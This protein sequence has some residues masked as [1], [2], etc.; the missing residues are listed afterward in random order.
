MAHPTI[1]KHVL[2][3]L[4]VAMILAYAPSC[5]RTMPERLEPAGPNPP[6]IWA[7]AVTNIRPNAV[8]VSWTTD[9]PATSEVLCRAVD[10]GRFRRAADDRLTKIHIVEQDG[11]K[12]GKTY[13]LQVSSTAADGSRGVA[14]GSTFTP[15]KMP[16]RGRVKFEGRTLLGAVSGMPEI[17]QAA[18]MHVD[19][20]DSAWDSLMPRPHKWDRKRLDAYI[21]KVKA[22]RA[23]GIETVVTLDYCVKW[24]LELTGTQATWRHPAFGPPDHLS[25]WKEFC[26][27][28]MEGLKDAPQWYE[29]WNEPDAGFFARPLG[30]EG[31]VGAGRKLVID[32]VFQKNARYWLQDR[33]APLVFAAR[34]AA[35]EVGVDA[36]LMAAGWNHDYHGTRGDMLLK[37]GVHNVIDAYSFHCYTGRPLSF[38][39]WRQGFETYLRHI[40]RIFAA[41]KIEL[42]LVMTEYGF[43]NFGI[44]EGDENLV[45]PGDRAVQIAKATLLALSKHR[46]IT[47]CM[48]NLAK[49]DM[50]LVENASLPLKPRPMFFAY[51]HLVDR[52][53]RRQYER[54]DDVIAES[55][56][57]RLN[58]N[59]PE[60]ELWHHAFRFPES[61][62]IF[63]AAWQGMKDKETKLPKRFPARLMTFRVPAPPGEKVWRLHH[64][65]LRGK[66]TPINVQPGPDGSLT[67]S[68]VLR[69]TSPD[70]ETE[71]TYFLLKLARRAT[72]RIDLDN[73]SPK[74]SVIK[75]DSGRHWVCDRGEKIGLIGPV[76]N[77]TDNC[78]ALIRQYPGHAVPEEMLVEPGVMSFTR[79][80]GLRLHTYWIT[81]KTFEGIR[82][83]VDVSEAAEQVQFHLKWDKPETNETGIIDVVFAYDAQLRRYTVTADF[84]LTVNKRGGGEFC[85]LYTYGLGDLRPGVSKYDRLLWTGPDGKM[86]LQWLGFPCAQPGPKQ[87]QKTYYGHRGGCVLPYFPIKPPAI[88]LPEGGLMAV[89]DE[90][91]GNPAV[92]VESASPQVRIDVCYTWFDVH[93]IWHEPRNVK[94][95][96]YAMDLPGPPYRYK[97]KLKA[98]WLGWEDSNRLL[99]GAEQLP[100]DQAAFDRYIPIAMNK[101]N[102]LEWRI[103]ASKPPVK[104]I[105]LWMNP[106]GGVSYDSTQ[107]R[108]GK[109]S[110]LFDG[111]KNPNIDA[112]SAGPELL[113]TPGK[114]LRIGAWVKTQNVAGEGFWLDSSFF[115]SKTPKDQGKHGPF[116]S[117]KLTGTNDWT[118]IE[119]PMP[120]TPW[121]ALWLPRRIAFVLKGTGKV[122][123]DD[124]V[125]A[126]EEP[127]N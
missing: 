125:F 83:S 39:G 120:V 115:L 16:L 100:L 75:L 57:A 67:W 52:F 1:V 86:K 5:S 7:V 20:F 15:R 63:V 121:D 80:I 33:Y 68:A 126:E 123:L 37:I 97:A 8:R 43:E 119:V 18:G 85:D 28:L 95:R 49:G 118:Y 9:R 61:G 106:K 114:Q 107:A 65:D 84:D 13:Q 73:Y 102:D 29:V 124:L 45:S 103:D 54:C 74:F 56:G 21:A 3:L 92:V 36:L 50:A 108:S 112:R 11:L 30:P 38:E 71:P 6:K 117:R 62:E 90:E 40:D 69:A 2:W 48:Y 32:P 111:D 88:V 101:V 27:G 53:S 46:F 58:D 96:Q 35:E 24:A 59:G 17:V 122:W 31:K 60:S 105:Y 23:A 127:Q 55:N 70:R 19:R 4:P 76:G 77:G 79:K 99:A 113:V 94:D 72:G 78:V 44:A 82:P 41:H 110:I 26:R 51:K 42:P 81:N 109:H 14:D 47:L 87:P 93:F 116:R 25:D 10:A 91:Q 64:V 12:Q 98:S 104:H 22:F 66:E 34:E 89:V